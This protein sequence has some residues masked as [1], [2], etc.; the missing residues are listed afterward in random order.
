M[1][2]NFYKKN[3]GLIVFFIF[4]LSLIFGFYIDENLNY[5]AVP[6]WKYTDLPVIN[7]LSF[8]IKKTLLN[9]ESYGHRHSPVYL[10]LLS[11]FKKI[12]ISIDGIRLFHLNLSLLLI[13]FFYKCL[14]LKFSKIEKN[15]LLLLSLTIFLSPTFR[16]LAI[17][18]SS[19]L[20]GLIFF[21]I[22]VYEFLKYLKDQKKMNM[23][24]NII[25]LII[26]SYISPNFSLFI[27][28]FLYHYLEKVNLKNLIYLLFFCLISALPAFY[29]IFI[30]EVN[31]LSAGTP[32]KDL[33]SSV[34][35][36]FNFSD[37]VLIISSILFFHLTPL[38]FN[39]E[40][41]LNFTKLP[42]NEF[43][44][45]SIFFIINL[46]FF[47]YSINYTGGGVFFQLSNF[48]FN[49]N[50]FFYFISFVSLMLLINLSKNSINN[51]L[52]FFLLI[53]S[54]V[55]NTIYHKY[56]DP[57]VLIL[58]FTLINNP[59]SYKF[60]ENKRNIY[61]VYIFYLIFISMRIVK[62]DYLS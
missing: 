14:V 30:L 5:G 47:N 52:I 56:Y 55:Q 35:L 25:F 9:Y 1:N 22:S 58:F 10:I 8:N 11:L 15:I 54:N 31:F 32:G 59:L 57:L 60:F 34:S 28:F 18:P 61:F 41:I 33:G 42:K 6:D 45:I 2:D 13:Y 36:G 53:L 21:T 12:G 26:S 46:F 4:Y 23:W 16:S 29:Y 3:F 49:N 40:F 20:I 17:W 62:N 38:L 39:R 44:I 50:Y 51:F 19:R 24:K 48:F 43:L 7:D 37:K 27:I